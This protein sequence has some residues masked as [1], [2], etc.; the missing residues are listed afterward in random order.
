MEGSVGKSGNRIITVQLVNA[1]NGYHLWSERYDREMRD[2]FDVQDEITLAVVNA[3]KL[4]LLGEKKADILKRSTKDTE[5]F[6]LYLRGLFYYNKRT[7]DDIRKAI[8]L[9]G[10]AIEKDPD[11][12]LAYASVQNPTTR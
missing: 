8:G 11:Y 1:T 6:E 9:F 5:A 4:K 2:I 12:A 7:A 10:Q 3:L